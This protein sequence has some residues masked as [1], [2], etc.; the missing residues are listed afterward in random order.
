MRKI[1]FLAFFIFILLF[2]LGVPSPA[3]ASQGVIELKTTVGQRSRC[4]VDSVLMSDLNFT[5]LFNC[6]DLIYPPEPTLFSYVV[7]ATPTSGEKPILLGELGTGKTEFRSAQAFSE[8]FVTTEPTLGVQS[9]SD[10]TV[11]R[12]TVRQVEFLDGPVITPTPTPEGEQPTPTPTKAPGRGEEIATRIRQTA[13]IILVAL[14]AL[15]IF[16]VIAISLLRR[17]RG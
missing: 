4:L 5:L 7:W 6:R 16:A 11:M 14:F 10:R 1:P 17:L 9:P 12:G 2:L 3:Q 13:I 8:L 15:V